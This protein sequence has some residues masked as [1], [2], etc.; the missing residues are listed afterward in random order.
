MESNYSLKD[1]AILDL[2][3]QDLVNMMKLKVGRRDQNIL[4]R[5]DLF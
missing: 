3:K 2:A 4:T 5:I 1:D